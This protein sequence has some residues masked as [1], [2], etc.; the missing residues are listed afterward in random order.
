MTEPRTETGS[1]AA[2]SGKRRSSRSLIALAAVVAGVCATTALGIWQLERRVWKLALIERVDQRVHAAPV[3]PPAPA[4]WRSV[5]AERDE[6]RRVRITGHFSSVRPALVQAV[7]ELG[8]GYWVLSPFETDAGYTVL[9]N[10]GFVPQEQRGGTQPPAAQSMAV[11][12]LLRLSEPGG[13][14]LRHNDARADRWYSRD[15]LAI[16]ASRGLGEVAPYFV[17]ADASSDAAVWP[18][19]GLTV[20]IFPNNHLVY[21]ITWFGLGLALVV[22]AILGLRRGDERR[23]IRK[24]DDRSRVDPTATR[25]SNSRISRISA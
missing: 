18:K 9:V 4:E 22:A 17:D 1:A 16:A 25:N 19:G 5:S 14:F 3:A 2:S 15:V 23:G 13:A 7:T 10:R 11:T 21:A 20:I 6:Y 8:G 24:Y 12:G